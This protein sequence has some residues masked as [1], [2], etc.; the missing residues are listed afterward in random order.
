MMDNLHIMLK[1][2]LNGEY[3]INVKNINYKNL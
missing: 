1:L 3:V 2:R